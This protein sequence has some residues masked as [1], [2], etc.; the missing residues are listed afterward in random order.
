MISLLRD[1]KIRTLISTIVRSGEMRKPD[2]SRDGCGLVPCPPNLS[3]CLRVP[4]ACCRGQSEVWFILSLQVNYRQFAA[5]FLCKSIIGNSQ[6]CCGLSRK[7]QSVLKPSV[8]SRPNVTGFRGP[9]LQ[10]RR[11]EHERFARTLRASGLDPMTTRA[12]PAQ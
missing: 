8:S 3:L 9:T 12:F 10:G 4:I 1:S 7:G 2:V 6:R 5:G 11:R